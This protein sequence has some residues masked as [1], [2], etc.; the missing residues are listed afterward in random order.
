[1]VTDSTFSEKTYFFQLKKIVKNN[2]CNL[3]FETLFHT[4]ILHQN[5]NSIKKELYY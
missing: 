5:S 2:F 4:N 1:M 3:D